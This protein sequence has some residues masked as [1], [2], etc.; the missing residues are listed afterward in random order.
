MA[1]LSSESHW[2]PSATSHSSPAIGHAA[3][4][5]EPRSVGR[6]ETPSV[7][8]SVV[9]RKQKRPAGSM[10]WGA[11][12]VAKR[13]L[14]D[15]VVDDEEEFDDACAA[16]FISAPEAAEARASTR[17]VVQRLAVGERL[18]DDSIWPRLDAAVALALSP[19][20]HH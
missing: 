12:Q 14:H 15:V 1:V 16:G 19:L 13:G 11:Y 4:L 9:I 6:A 17:E 18:F 10:E 2:A 3:V 20:R 8:E 5:R 7:V